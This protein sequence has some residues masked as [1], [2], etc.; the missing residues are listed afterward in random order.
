MASSHENLPTTGRSSDDLTGLDVVL[1]EDS[2]DVGQAVRA[3]LELC[4]ATVAGPAATIADA[5]VLL[6][7]HL[8]DVAIVDLHLRGGERSDSLIARL[9][10]QGVPII[11]LSGSF[12]LASMPSMEGT[13]IIEK[14]VSEAQ[15]IAHLSPLIAKKMAR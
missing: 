12:E 5:E 6:A 1:V 13:I 2:W 7:C 14:P 4:G 3:L 15:L 8:P 11:M 9:R 10:E